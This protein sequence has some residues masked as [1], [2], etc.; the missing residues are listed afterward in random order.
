MALNESWLN[1]PSRPLQLLGMQKE[2]S[3]LQAII[4]HALWDVA[5]VP[6]TASMALG[7]VNRSR[8]PQGFC[9]IEVTAVERVTFHCDF[10]PEVQSPLH[11]GR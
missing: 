5:L 1:P 10:P 7:T 8:A 4:S 6:S 3:R 11:C 2:A 9:D